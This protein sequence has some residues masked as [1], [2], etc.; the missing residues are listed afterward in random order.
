MSDQPLV[1]AIPSKGRI[2][3]GTRAFFTRAGLVT[4]KEAGARNYTGRF[5]GIPHA[6]VLF[7]SAGEIPAALEE[8]T[9]HL[10]I[11]GEDLMRERAQDAARSIML[12]L[13]LGFS[14]ADVV[15]AVPSAWIDVASMAD[16]DEVAHDFRAR[17]RR[18]LRVATKYF[19]L[20]R[21][22]FAEHGLID[23][24]IVESAGA[25]EGAPA[26]GLAE[27]IVDITTTGATLAANSLK[28]LPDGVIL[29]SQAQLA[30]SRKAV[31]SARA[32]AAARQVLDLI[33][34]AQQAQ[35][36]SLRFAFKGEAATLEK[37]LKTLSA[38]A[39][40]WPAGGGEL[41]L[42]FDERKA[43]EVV[44]LL[45]KHGV[46]GPLA[47]ARPGQYFTPHNPLIDAVFKG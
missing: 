47:T 42:Y 22:F 43:Y 17:H 25:T 37:A 7:L 41:S 10:G 19:K 4:Q 5:A 24:R 3:E 34:A 14:K 32:K 9:A 44:T 2:E 16:L 8:G 36:A 46:E 15:V 23:Y 18:H 13:P 30:A 1:F 11:T 21:S 29:R 27:I 20:T 26:S 31:W 6:E 40:L 33:W 12:I 35:R 38:D 39:A 45:R 28:V